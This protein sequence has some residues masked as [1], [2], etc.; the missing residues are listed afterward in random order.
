[1][2]PASQERQAVSCPTCRGARWVCE[3]NASEPWPHEGCGGAGVPCVRHSTHR[4]I[5]AGCSGVAR[6]RRDSDGNYLSVRA[7]RDLRRAGG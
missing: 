2:E 5:G 1:M 7:G 6:A 4:S 3:D